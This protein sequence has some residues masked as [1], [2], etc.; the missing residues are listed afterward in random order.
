[1]SAP[2]EREPR[3]VTTGRVGDDV[4]HPVYYNVHPSGVEC[5]DINEALPANLA[6]VYKYVWRCDEKDA[7]LRDLKKALWY[8][9]REAA[10]AQNDPREYL[11][12]VQAEA[13]R[14][15]PNVIALLSRV[16]RS[17]GEGTLAAVSIALS[18][19]LTRDISTH[20]FFS[21]LVIAI[22]SAIHAR[23]T[24]AVATP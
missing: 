16:I 19:F 10:Y 11:Y 17:G 4:A 3:K 23:E 1:M 7:P 20:V 22:G 12:R 2:I 6:C 24:A 5:V 9:K 8:A 18:D 15:Q 21:E 13:L 14:R